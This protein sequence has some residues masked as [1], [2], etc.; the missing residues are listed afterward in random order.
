M[1]PGKHP[2]V[3]FKG[4]CMSPQRQLWVG[5]VASA[6]AGEL[7]TLPG[8]LCSP[9]RKYGCLKLMQSTLSGGKQKLVLNTERILARNTPKM[10]HVTSQH[11]PV[12]MLS[13]LRGEAHPGP[14][15]IATFGSRRRSHVRWSRGK[16]DT[17]G[18]SLSMFQLFEPTVSVFRPG[19]CRCF[20]IILPSK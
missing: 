4:N 3:C 12:H 20:V 11:R 15:C 17:A 19:D 5:V 1:I 14:C 6:V 2:A 10:P 7:V 18:C 9:W 8:F 16:R 13:L